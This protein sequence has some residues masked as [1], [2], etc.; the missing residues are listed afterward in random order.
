MLFRSLAIDIIERKPVAVLRK[1][2]RLV[3]IDATGHELQAV[4]EARAKGRLVIAGPGA[5]QQVEALNALLGAAPAMKPQVAEAEWIGNRRW[6][7]TFKTGQVLALPE[8]EPQSAKA[9]MT[10]AR[11]DGVNRLLGGKAL[12]FDMRAPDRIYFRLAGRTDTVEKPAISTKTADAADA[13][14]P[15]GEDRKS[16]V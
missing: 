4:S 2:D 5:G 1:P 16:V 3:L 9:L 8:G 11:L 14:K 15:K 10:F 6:N 12:A 7:L 13:P